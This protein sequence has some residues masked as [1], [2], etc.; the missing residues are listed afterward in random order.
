MKSIEIRH[1]SML[2]ALPSYTTSSVGKSNAICRRI[3]VA[4]E[5]LYQFCRSDVGKMGHSYLLGHLYTS[6]TILTLYCTVS[7]ATFQFKFHSIRL[8]IKKS[9]LVKCQLVNFS[10]LQFYSVSNKKDSLV[11][12]KW[13]NYSL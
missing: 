10:L 13:V 7:C 2:S 11:T 9:C 3:T 1:L 8:L 5:R 12:R 4:L 6:D